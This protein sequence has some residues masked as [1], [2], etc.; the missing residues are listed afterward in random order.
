MMTPFHVNDAPYDADLFCVNGAYSFFAQTNATFSAQTMPTYSAPTTA[1][2][3][4]QTMY[5]YSA[6]RTKILRKHCPPI[7]YKR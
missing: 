1:T 5:T 2:F 7:L 4:A 6:N 3:S